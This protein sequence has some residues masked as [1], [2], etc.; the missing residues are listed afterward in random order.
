[1]Q[2]FRVGCAYVAFVFLVPMSLLQTVRAQN[3]GSAQTKSKQ[4]APSAQSQQ[5]AMQ[6]SR[7]APDEESV[8]MAASYKKKQDLGSHSTG[9]GTCYDSKGAE[10]S[11]NF[12]PE[13]AA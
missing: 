10:E 11:L 2:R 13:K 5:D 9:P 3:S 7:Q 12:L 8:N 1:M 6:K 4:N